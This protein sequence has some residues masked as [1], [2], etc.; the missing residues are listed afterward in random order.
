MTLNDRIVMF[1]R[2]VEDGG[3]TRP[4]PLNRA[5]EHKRNEYKLYVGKLYKPG[6]VTRAAR[7]SWGVK[8]LPIQKSK[9]REPKFPTIILSDDV[10]AIKYLAPKK[11]ETVVWRSQ[12]GDPDF[13]GL[14]TKEPRATGRGAAQYKFE[15][16][17]PGLPKPHDTETSSK[18][19]FERGGA[20]M[21]MFQVVKPGWTAKRI[22][23]ENDARV[24]RPPL[25]VPARNILQ[26]AIIIK[27]AQNAIAK[28]LNKGAGP[29]LVARNLDTTAARARIRL[30]RDAMESANKG[31]KGDTGDIGGDGDNGIVLEAFTNRRGLATIKHLIPSSMEYRREQQWWKAYKQEMTIEVQ[32]PEKKRGPKTGAAWINWKKRRQKFHQKNARKTT[33]E[34][35][36]NRRFYQDME[37]RELASVIGTRIHQYLHVKLLGDEGGRSNCSQFERYAN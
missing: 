15:I 8:W 20:P 2:I 37:I 16:R 32:I 18:W 36:L 26:R 3:D 10:E 29:L 17:F 28:D 25:A 4:V 9:N 30:V 14:V 12:N 21:N 31:W 1:Y 19:I 33:L 7:L 11:G 23:Q 35:M 27:S 22:E 13:Y 24:A 34:K 6:G 5:P